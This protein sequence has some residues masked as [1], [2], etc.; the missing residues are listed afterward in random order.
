[1]RADFAHQSYTRG[2]PMGSDLRPALYGAT[3]PTFMTRARRDPDGANLDR[4]QIVKGWVENGEARE[5]IWDMACADGRAIVDDSCEGDVGNTANVAEATFENMI[6][7]AALGGVWTDPDFDPDRRSM[8][9]VRVLEIPKP[10]WTSFD[11]K[12]FLFFLDDAV[13]ASPVSRYGSAKVFQRETAAIFR[14]EPVIECRQR[15]AGSGEFSDPQDRG[16]ADALDPG[17]RG[18]GSCVFECVPASGARLVG[19]ASGCKHAFSCPYHAWTWSNSGDLRG[20]PHEKPGFPE[21]D[22]AA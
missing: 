11:A 21:I 8:Y 22:R 1:M 7:D 12:F 14:K 20:I 6:G 17:S 13:E 18:A 19:E 10:R 15:I 5:R 16:A 9:Y 4:I 2:V 3:A